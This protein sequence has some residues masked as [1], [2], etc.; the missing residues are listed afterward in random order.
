MKDYDK[1]FDDFLGGDECEMASDTLYAVIREA[2]I[3]GWRAARSPC[4]SKTSRRGELC[5]PVVSLPLPCPR[6]NP[7]AQGAH[8]APLHKISRQQFC[9]H[10]LTV[11]QW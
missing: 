4:R 8:I 2:F 9:N 6:N 10:Y 1:A 3:A 11:P 7:F 5:S